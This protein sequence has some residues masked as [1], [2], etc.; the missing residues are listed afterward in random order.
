MNNVSCDTFPCSSNNKPQRRLTSEDVRKQ[1]RLRE[2]DSWITKHNERIGSTGTLRTR[3]QCNER[4]KQEAVKEISKQTKEKGKPKQRKT[5]S[6]I[7]KGF[8]CRTWATNFL[9]KDAGENE[10]DEFVPFFVR[11]Y[12]DNSKSIGPEKKKAVVT[13]TE[14]KRKTSNHACGQADSDAE[15]TEQNTTENVTKLEIKTKDRP[16]SDDEDNIETKEQHLENWAGS[17]LGLKSISHDSICCCGERLKHGKEMKRPQSTIPLNRA[18]HQRARIKEKTCVALPIKQ[19]PPINPLEGTKKPKFLSGRTVGV[20]PTRNRPHTVDSALLS[21]EAILVNGHRNLPNYIRASDSFTG[22]LRLSPENLNKEKQMFSRVAFERDCVDGKTFDEAIR[23]MSSRREAD[24]EVEETVDKNETAKSALNE[25]KN[26][27]VQSVRSRSLSDPRGNE[28]W[29]RRRIGENQNV[30]Y[31]D[32]GNRPAVR[33]PLNSIHNEDDDSC[34]DSNN[35]GLRS[36]IEY[37]FDGSAKLAVYLHPRG[38]S[39]H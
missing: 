38:A 6:K 5:K 26:L 4:G 13:L 23:L 11:K 9:P 37:T 7:H 8:V 19:F 29:S 15:T 30:L 2:A 17:G 35:N 1:I 10:E 39:C 20:S 24:K 25:L 33:T 14:G 22:V 34:T 31:R 3:A 27:Q 12:V 28:K 21:K 16:N 32:V 36:E 18:S